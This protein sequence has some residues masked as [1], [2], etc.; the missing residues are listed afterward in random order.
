[1]KKEICIITGCTS[2]L[3]Y[4]ILRGFL[5]KNYKIYGISNNIV[6]IKKTIK[7][8]KDENYNL[9][10]FFLKRV[11]VSN[12]TEVKNFIKNIIKTEKKIDILISNAGVYGPIGKFEEINPLKWK[13]AFEINFFGSINMFREVIPIMKK[14][15]YGRIIQISGGGAT[16]SLPMFTSYASA[17]VAIVRFAE[18]I[19]DELKNYNININSIAPGALNTI[20]LDQA[21]K[22]GPNKTGKD[23][24][25]KMLLIKKKGGDNMGKTVD[26]CLQLS[27]KKS[28]VNGKLISSLWDKWS[29]FISSKKLNKTDVYTLRRIIG[30]DRKLKKFD[31]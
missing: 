21:L 26:L 6:K 2:G 20:F 4:E 7:K 17:K 8:L 14:K 11:N 30:S 28:K 31:V 23:F 19:S 10:N 12:Q 16:K 25:K 9:N 27:N 15:N 1:M 13:K 24:Y 22:A 18:T 5:K 29:H 3:G